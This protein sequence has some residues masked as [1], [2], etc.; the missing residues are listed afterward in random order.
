MHGEFTITSRSVAVITMLDTQKCELVACNCLSSCQVGRLGCIAHRVS[1]VGDNV[2][3]RVSVRDTA[4]VNELTFTA[5]SKLGVMQ[6]MT[7][8]I[9][10]TEMIL[11]E[12]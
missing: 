7:G 6:I 10:H 8:W 5:V 11:K 9:Q 12:L 2:D 3:Q 1:G 4:G